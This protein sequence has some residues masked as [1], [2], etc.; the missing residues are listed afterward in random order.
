M[1]WVVLAIQATKPE[2]WEWDATLQSQVHS[3]HFAGLTGF[4]KGLTW[5]GNTAVVVATFVGI[6]LVLLVRHARRYALVFTMLGLLELGNKGVQAAIGRPRPDPTI[7]FG[8]NSFPS[9]HAFHFA[10]LGGFLLYLLL[11]H[12]PNAGAR[13]LACAVYV[14]VALA[15][16]FSRVHLGYHWP[17]DV[18]GGYLLAVPVLAFIVL[19]NHRLQRRTAKRSTP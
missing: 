12:L 11:P 18:L 6:V 5:L 13:W 7:Q 1:L 16:G 10:L 2:P 8:T 17:T 19:L 9:G 3:W 4:L 15:A 14:T